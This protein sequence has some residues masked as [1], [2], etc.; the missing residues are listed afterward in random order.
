[1]QILLNETCLQT[2]NQFSLAEIHEFY[3]LFLS[4]FFYIWFVFRLPA[5][6]KTE[7]NFLAFYVT[8]YPDALYTFNQ[9]QYASK[10]C[11]SYS[12]YINSICWKIS[13]TLE[14]QTPSQVLNVHLIRLRHAYTELAFGL[15][16]I[17]GTCFLSLHDA[18][19]WCEHK[20]L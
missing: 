19:S 17:A 4:I 13:E 5:K 10:S 3:T 2:E 6:K 1:M 11:Y 15:S 12:D 9:I 7:Q 16:A 14:P 20:S 18:F 8:V